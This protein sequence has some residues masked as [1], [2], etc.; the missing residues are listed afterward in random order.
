MSCLYWSLCGSTAAA[1]E[2]YHPQDYASDVVELHICSHDT[3]KKLIE[4]DSADT[5][6]VAVTIVSLLMMRMHLFAVNSRTASWR[7]HAATTCMSTVWF[8][9]FQSCGNKDNPHT[10]LPNKQ[11]MLL[12]TIS[13]L[14]LVTRDDVS[15]PCW[16]TSEASEQTYGCWRMTQSDLNLEQLIGIVNK[17]KI[18]FNAIYSSGLV[19]AR[20]NCTLKG[21]LSTF[22]E[23][24]ET[25]KQAA[26][27][28]PSSGPELLMIQSSCSSTLG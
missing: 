20:S 23:Y 18:C 6:N 28:Q 25:L 21:Y 22:R 1:K 24:V 3:L 26:S 2:L 11:N 12:E 8:T 7:V 5:G 4:N 14:L 16:L 27:K 13:L 19:T 15:Q 17:T 10:M 9:S